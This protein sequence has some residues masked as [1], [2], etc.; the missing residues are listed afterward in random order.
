MG[1]GM[2]QLLGT[3]TLGLLALL[4]V[5]LLPRTAATREPDHREFL[6]TLYAPYRA[7]PGMPRDE[8]EARIFLLNFS[9]YYVERPQDA[10]WLLEIV[11]ADGRVVRTWHGVERLYRKAVEVKVYWNGRGA[12]GE[13]PTA[14]YLARLQAMSRPATRKG[15]PRPM[16]ERQVRRALAQEEGR[17]EQAWDVTIGSPARPTFVDRVQGTCGPGAFELIRLSGRTP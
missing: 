17:I 5:L 16:R 13:L 1:N 3:F 8:P 10:L 11:A 6:A 9:Y 14:V 7:E 2:R 12:C 4:A 15:L